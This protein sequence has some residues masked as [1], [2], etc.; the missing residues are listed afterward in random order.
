VSDRKSCAPWGST[1]AMTISDHQQTAVGAAF[2]QFYRAN[3]ARLAELVTTSTPSRLE[4]PARLLV[5]PDTD[6]QRLQAPQV[7]V[8][9][10]LKV[11]GC[12][13]DLLE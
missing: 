12:K 8:R 7:D 10:P 2:G 11:I 1:V 5:L 6:G 13:L 3:D 4:T 9:A